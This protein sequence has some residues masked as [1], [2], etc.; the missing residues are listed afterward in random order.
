MAADTQVQ[1]SEATRQAFES[2][3]CGVVV[4]AG[5]N[6]EV[7][8]ANRFL[9]ELCGL[10]ADSARHVRDFVPH[11][12]AARL[13]ERVDQT[14][15]A[16]YVGIERTLRRADGQTFVASL[17]A[18]PYPSA[19][20]EAIVCFVRNVSAERSFARDLGGL[21]RTLAFLDGPE[22]FERLVQQISESVG[23]KHV[24]V[25]RMDG[26][27]AV[28]TLAFWS[29]DS[30]APNFGYALAGTPCEN[31]LDGRACVYPNN[32]VEHFPEDADLVALNAEAY[33]G[34][35]LIDPDGETL[36]H[37]FGV[38][39]EALRDHENV[40]EVM[41]T[42][43]PLVASQLRQLLVS[44]KAA[45]MERQLQQS[46]K[47]E[48]LGVLAGGIA[49]DFNNL[50][51]AILGNAELAALSTD[52]PE[53]HDHLELVQRG[54]TKAAELC[55]QV[56]AYAG[57]GR[58]QEQEL[59]LEDAVQEVVPLL[60]AGRSED[61][62]IRLDLP[63]LP[64]RVSAD[65]SQVTQLLMNLVTNGLEAIGS[66]PGSVTIATGFT[67]C[68]GECLAET[69]LGESACAGAF[70]F[71]DVIDD[72]P[73]L[74]PTVAASMFD[75]FYSTKE[76]GRG[77][78]LST[79]L[80]IV[81]AH[82]GAIRV[83]TP[84]GG[85][86]RIRILLPAQSKRTRAKAMSTRLGPL[87]GRTVLLA[88]DDEAV[89]TTTAALLER[90]GARVLLACDGQQAID[91][92]RRRSDE[93]DA[94][95]LDYSMPNADGEEAFESIRAHRADARVLLM[96][97]Y[98]AESVSE[99]LLRRGLCGFLPKPFSGEQ[100]T[101]TMQRVVGMDRAAIA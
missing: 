75:P 2:L 90:G 41:T 6:G 15:R 55:R 62:T 50:L 23:L 20:P 33:I 82:A 37:L 64:T 66:S 94:V 86:T 45:M 69:Y 87:A 49:H 35:R 98:D 38:H 56:L 78:G 97:G 81:K 48:S 13:G 101:E 52:S 43:A 58:S 3:G 71:L 59:V 28:R 84:A 24:A 31:V 32:V 91:L 73:G 30:L 8:L 96:T 88:D 22:F 11:F 4:V 19:G 51:T 95:L 92:F 9:L 40:L 39:D 46:Q 60:E 34:V 76:N 7:L 10:D 100:L 80:G 18:Q 16:G 57:E 27:D 12:D 29:G 54:A 99:R 72:G 63:Q 42:Y 85:G 5:K 83:D 70:A 68:D 25:C 89:R 77:L 65:P 47:L 1:I 44:E 36:G 14:W 67:D 26:R 17:G 61:V 79:V 53:T 74:S 93:I 21:I